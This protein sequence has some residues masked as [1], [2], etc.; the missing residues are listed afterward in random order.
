VGEIVVVTGAD[1]PIGRRVIAAALAEP[2]VDRVVAVGAQPSIRRL[3]TSSDGPELLLAPFALDDSRLVPL[4]MGATRVFLTGP[5]SGLDIDGTS[6]SHI[7]VTAA[8]AFLAALARVGAVSTVVVLSSAL[9]YGARTDN[10][11][12]LTEHAPVRPNSAINASNERAELERLCGTWARSRGS[13]CAVVRPSI[14]VGPENGKWLARSSWATAGLQLSGVVAP[15]QF[16]HLDDLTTALI[17]V[18]RARFDGPINVAP[19]GWLAVDEVRALKGPTARL[20]MRK[21]FAHVLA[22]LGEHFGV[23]PGDPDALLASSG[24]WVVAN[25]RIRSLGWMPTFSN[26]EAY[27]DSDR[28]GVW[29]RLTPRHRQRLALGTLGALVLSVA[30]GAAVLIRRHLTADR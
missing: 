16:L 14:V 30:G 5:R 24:Q 29:A 12:P 25:D 23:A 21:P 20:R 2:G 17:T 11:I 10:P 19:D 9:V 1:L 15:V 7:D 18:C 27:V 26:E 8:R 13:T 22:R 4:V 6:G 3:E 28:G